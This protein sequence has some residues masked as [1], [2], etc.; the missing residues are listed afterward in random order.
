MWKFVLIV[1][2]FLECRK[3]PWMW[4]SSLNAEKL[5]EYEIVT[6][7]WES[8]FNVEKIL[9]CGKLT[10]LTVQKVKGLII[11]KANTN[12]ETI[13]TYISNLGQKLIS[14]NFFVVDKINI[15]RSKRCKQKYWTVKGPLW[16]LRHFLT[17]EISLTMKKIDFYFISK[18]IFILKIFNFL[19]WLF[20]HV[21]KRLD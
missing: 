14:L 9:D 13:K 3:V 8:S 12:V 6:W 15:M 1:E 19:S 21:S 17:T 20:G 10:F 2:K 16:G 4:K 7:I 18:A 5:F 11:S